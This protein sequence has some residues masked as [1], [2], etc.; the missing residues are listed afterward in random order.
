MSEHEDRLISLEE[1][2]M[3]Q[4]RLLE[5]LD[6][7]VTAQQGVIEKL[8]RDLARLT[9]QISEGPGEDVDEPPPHY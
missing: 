6:E 8:T 3:H 4:E 5:R 7:V 1:R 9:E 2:L